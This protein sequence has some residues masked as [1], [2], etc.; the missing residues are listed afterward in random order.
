MSVTYVGEPVRA[1]ETGR[2]AITAAIETRLIREVIAEPEVHS[3]QS[4]VE[5]LR[6]VHELVRSIDAPVPGGGHES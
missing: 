2:A 4:R 6:T 5:E 3:S 1:P